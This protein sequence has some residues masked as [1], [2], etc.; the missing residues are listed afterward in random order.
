MPIVIS[1]DE[2]NPKEWMIEN[3]HRKHYNHHYLESY[4]IIILEFLPG[5]AREVKKNE[6]IL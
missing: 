6:F 3:K 4:I 2:V 1:N 5:F